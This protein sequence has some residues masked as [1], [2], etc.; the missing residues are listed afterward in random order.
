MEEGDPPG[1]FP[2]MSGEAFCDVSSLSLLLSIVDGIILASAKVLY[3]A[4]FLLKIFMFSTIF[5]ESR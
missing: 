5:E 3:S 4:C 2:C 1:L